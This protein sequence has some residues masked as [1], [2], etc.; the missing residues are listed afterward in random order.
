MAIE[1]WKIIADDVEGQGAELH[2]VKLMETENNYVEYYGP[3]K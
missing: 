2:S 1:I 3:T